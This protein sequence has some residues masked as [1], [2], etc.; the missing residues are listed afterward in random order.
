[1]PVGIQSSSRSPR[2]KALLN[3]QLLEPTTTHVCP[4]TLTKKDTYRKYR[5]ERSPGNN[6]LCATV[7][8]V[9]RFLRAT[10]FGLRLKGNYGKRSHLMFSQD[11]T[12]MSC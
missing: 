12:P 4:T 2:H 1:M 6:I 11:L 10:P 3:E 7:A 9:C 8:T 5:P